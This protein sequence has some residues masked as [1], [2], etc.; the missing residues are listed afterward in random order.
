VQILVVDDSAAVRGRLAA[1]LSS[2]LPGAIVHEADD[3]DAA[4]VLAG[5]QPIDVVVLDLHMPRGDG[6]ELIAAFRALARPPRVLVLTADATEQHRHACLAR[7]AE[8]F[9]DKATDFERVAA[10]ILSDNASDAV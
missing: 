6:L 10:L 7:G 5:A 9:L 3:A 2:D 4:L 1:L 8:A